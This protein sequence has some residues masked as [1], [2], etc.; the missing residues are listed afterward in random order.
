MFKEKAF[1]YCLKKVAQKS[2]VFKLIMTY[3]DC[4]LCEPNTRRLVLSII[5]KAMKL[6]QSTFDLVRQQVQSRQYA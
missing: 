4:R 1:N 6:T 3:A 2:F 5:G